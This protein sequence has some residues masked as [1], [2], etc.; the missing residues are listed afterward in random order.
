MTDQTDTKDIKI[1]TS[2]PEGQKREYSNYVEIS[3]NPREVSLK[4]C[5]LKSPSTNEEIEKIKKEGITLLVNTEIVLAFDVA[6]SVVD[7]MTKQLNIV[8]EKLKEL[9]KEE[10][11]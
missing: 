11:K 7:T 9:K 8:K 6:E 1:V 4:F 2:R 3:A 10:Q 5:D